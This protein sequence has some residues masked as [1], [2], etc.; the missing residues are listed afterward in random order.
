MTL[1]RCGAPNN[2]KI[3]PNCVANGAVHA[4]EKLGARDGIGNI[5]MQLNGSVSAKY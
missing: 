1:T 2:L 3:D 5:D 4:N